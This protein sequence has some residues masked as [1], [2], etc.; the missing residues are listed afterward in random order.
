MNNRQKRGVVLLALGLILVLCGLVVHLGQSQEDTAAGQ[1][2]AVL[3]QQLDNKA[4]PTDTLTDEDVGVDTDPALPTKTYMGYT[5]IG[6]IFVPSVGIRL[7]ILN[8]WN[9]DMLKVAPCRYGGSLSGGDMIIMGH[10]YKSHFNP[11]HKIV[12]GAE[13]RIEN[14]VGKVFCYR[15]AKI[16]YLHRSQGEQL[17]SEEYPLTVFT[18]TPGGLNRMVLRCEAVES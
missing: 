4:L 3:L 2:A 13:I 7:P 1:M 5:M 17:P 16:E 14:T 9:E 12:E 15:V 8:E 11:L 6:S 10:N 18:C